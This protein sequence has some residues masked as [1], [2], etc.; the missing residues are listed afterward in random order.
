MKTAV[1]L[2]VAVLAN[3][4]AN[5]C[6]SKGMR[7]YGAARPLGTVW[8][9]E[10]SH[11]VVSNGWLIAGVLCLLIF[12]ASYLAALSWAD[13]SFVLPISSAGYFFQTLLAKIYLHEKVTPIR[14]WGTAI[15]ILGVFM[16]G[17]SY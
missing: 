7:Q 8:L 16:I 1:V 17:M 3:S 15:I 4:L 2:A 5:V 10:T 9:L 11:H 13:L 14:W 6:L 12:L